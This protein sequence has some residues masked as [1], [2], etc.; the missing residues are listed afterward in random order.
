[1]IT[2]AFFRPTWMK[3][4]AYLLAGMIID[5]DH[6]L[7]NPIYDPNRCSIGFHP[8]HTFFPILFYI[9]LLV[10]AKT[11]ILGIGLC[12]HIL[13]DAIDCQ[14]NSDGLCIDDLLP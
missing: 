6:L 11:R 7:A 1:M 3:S 9:A 12:V 4:L 14:I 13:L 8:L 10:P 2:V 5:V